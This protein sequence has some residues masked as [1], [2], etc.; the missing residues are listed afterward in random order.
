MKNELT[1]PYE[2]GRDATGLMMSDECLSSCAWLSTSALV[3]QLMLN[4]LSG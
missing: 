2:V 1:C 3:R 4:S